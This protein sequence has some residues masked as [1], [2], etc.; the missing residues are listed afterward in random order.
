MQQSIIGKVIDTYEI[1]GILG[2]GGMGVVYKAKDKTLERD[3]ALKMMEANLARDEEFLK[4]FKSEAKALAKLQNPNIVS[5]FALR[6]TELGLA[7]VMEFVEGNTLADQIRLQGPLPLHRTIKI[8]KQILGALGDAHRNNV[9]HRD[10]KPSN[11]MLTKDDVVKVTDFGLAKIQQVSSA[12]VTMGTGG[13]LY[14]MSPEQIRGLANVD[15]RGDIYSIG[16]TLYETLTGRVPFG[17]DLT[18]FDIRQMIVDGKIPPPERFNASL[19]KELVQITL[20][21]IHKDPNKRFQTCKEMAEALSAIQVS[22]K[23]GEAKPGTMAPPP[24]PPKYKAPVSPR[25]PLYITIAAG[26]VVIAALFV[27]RSFLTAPSAT[28]RVASEPPG[29]KVKLNG[30]VVGVTPLDLPAVEAGTLALQLDR[31]GYFVKDTQLIVREG[32]SAVLTVKLTPLPPP[33]TSGMLPAQEQKP[34]PSN[35]EPKNTE[36]V[37]AERK[38]VPLPKPRETAP[39]IATL[40]LRAVPSGSVTIDNGESRNLGN[41]GATL[42]VTSGSRTITFTHPKYGVKRTTITLKPGE[43]RQLTCYF[44]AYLSVVTS[45]DASWGLLVIDGKTTEVQTPIDGFA[46]GPGRHRISVAK[47]GFETV[48]GER[49]V[50]VEPSFERRVERLSFTLKRK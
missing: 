3:V 46:L 48:E 9:I 36:T 18:D 35:G 16:M 4:R 6:E 23:D 50:V 28:L 19:P 20:K 44:E 27:V 33:Q 30:T 12:T 39:A 43:R 11:V 26:A 49:V 13:T 38:G 17:N 14:Y 32:Q 7:L 5:V 34:E 31:E 45:G 47:M 29:S 42:E 8:F 15:A 24:K 41:D 21:A 37:V 1:T 40:V 22:P 25:R 2:K 10:I